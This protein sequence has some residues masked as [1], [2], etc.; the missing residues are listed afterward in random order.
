MTQ[1]KTKRGGENCYGHIVH[2]LLFCDFKFLSA[3]ASVRTSVSCQVRGSK[4]L[5]LNDRMAL[6]NATNGGDARLQQDVDT[7][8]TGMLCS[9]LWDKEHIDLV[10]NVKMQT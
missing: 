1:T 9:H 4:A 5:Y 3:N 8:H 10:D 2:L 6:F 7:V